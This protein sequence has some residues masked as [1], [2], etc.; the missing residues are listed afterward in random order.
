MIVLDASAAIDLLLNLAPRARFV[1]E[2]IERSAPALYAPHLLDAEVGE[3]LRRYVLQGALS[4]EDAEAALQDLADL[5]VT[6]Y[7][8]GPFLRRAFAMRDNVTV[9]DALYLALAE[10]LE[11]E[12]VTSDHALAHVPGCRARVAVAGS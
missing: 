7:P 5:P 4:P 10:S 8:H 12:L 2:R 1:R 6:R 3:V 11:A 9:Y